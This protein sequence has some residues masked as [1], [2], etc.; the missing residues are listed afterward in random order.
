MT[1]FPNGLPQSLSSKE[2]S[3]KAGDASLI[4]GLG[5]SSEEGNGNPHQYSCL[6]N[7]MDR[8]VWKAIVHGVT[9]TWTQLSD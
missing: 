9:K 1:E 7:P 4:P 2:S 3:C 8:G 6:E 5:R